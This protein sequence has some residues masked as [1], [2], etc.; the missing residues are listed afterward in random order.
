MGFKFR[1][2]PTNVQKQLIITAATA[3]GMGVKKYL[4]TCTEE[5]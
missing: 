3:A 4:H 5:H 2:E 1:E